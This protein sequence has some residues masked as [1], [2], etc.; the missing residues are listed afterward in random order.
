MNLYVRDDLGI[1]GGQF[2][3]YEGSQLE[4][5]SATSVQSHA[6]LTYEVPLVA[7][8]VFNHVSSPAVRRPKGTAAKELQ[9]PNQAYQTQHELN[10][11]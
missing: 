8:H 2:C 10:I 3:C 6:A 5:T 11:S 4:S 9:P 7:I 1:T